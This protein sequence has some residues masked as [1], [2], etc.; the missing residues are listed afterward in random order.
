MCTFLS[1][2]PKN[3]KHAKRWIVIV[4]ALLPCL[5]HA[6]TR[7]SEKQANDWY[8][9]QPWLLGADYLPA[10]A[11]NQLEMFQATS[12]DEAT[13]R[14]ELALA[15][16]IG[17]NT[18]RVYLHDLLWQ[19]DE[20]GFKKRLDS[21]L[22]VCAANGIKPVLVFFDSCWDPYPK[23]GKQREPQK[24]LH[25]S[26]W[27][28]SPGANVLANPAQQGELEKYVRD[29]VKTFQNDNR[30]LCWDVWNEPDNTNDNSYNKQELK[31][32]VEIVNQLLPQ[33][34]RWVKEEKPQQPVTA[35]LWTWW[36]WSWHPDS[37]HR[38]SETE[39]IILRNSD[40]ITF[41]HYGKPADFE[42]L[43]QHLK[44]YN[45]PLICTEYLA[46]GEGNTP[47]TVL[48]IAKKYNVGMINWGFVDGKEQT[49]YPWNSWD[50]PYETEPILWHHVLFRSDLTPYKPE[51][52][53][54]IKK[55]RAE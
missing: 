4:T 9:K 51:E 52:I 15:K 3:M 43:V 10:T 36:R 31:N 11:I 14:K 38:A 23:L 28:Q 45:R 40:I 24:G 48:P 32:K 17:F 22:A 8:A 47:I 42:T 2:I 25:N 44:K 29:V 12:F 13:F 46:R 7:W 34:F 16:D 53:A 50:K 39:K 1:P 26:G 41:H 5:V 33:V 37:L 19:Q 49:K 27:V 20:V 18:L 54:M 21:F 30:I 6:Q 35:G 55:L